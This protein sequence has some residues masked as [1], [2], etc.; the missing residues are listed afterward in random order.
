MINYQSELKYFNEAYASIPQCAKCEEV[1]NLLYK[2]IEFNTIEDIT[3]HYNS[4]KNNMDIR[5]PRLEEDLNS[6]HS[7]EDIKTRIV[8]CAIDRVLAKKYDMPK[9]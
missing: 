3:T 4:A 7:L 9:P 1:K 2:L 6:N 8:I 5:F